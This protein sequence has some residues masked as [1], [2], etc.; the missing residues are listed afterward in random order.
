MKFLLEKGRLCCVEKDYEGEAPYEVGVSVTVDKSATA[1][2]SDVEAKN[3]EEFYIFELLKDISDKFN[4]F[5]RHHQKD[6]DD[7]FVYFG[8]HVTDKPMTWEEA[9]VQYTDIAMGIPVE[10]YISHRHSDLTGYLWTNID[11]TDAKGH[12][13]YRE[14][15]DKIGD[16]YSSPK[17]LSMLFEITKK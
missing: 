2:W 4:H 17:Y 3:T 8:Y 11:I 1:F 5:K 9:S 15:V 16:Y 13:V 14:I 6:M 12:D 7:Y 10:S